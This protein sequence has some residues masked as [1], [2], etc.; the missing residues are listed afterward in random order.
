MLFVIK[1]EAESK[2]QM[3]KRI[4]IYFFIVILS[5]VISIPLFQENFD[6]Y[7][8]D[9]VQHICRLMGTYQSITEEQ[10]FPVIM[11]NFCNS[12]GYSWNLFYSPITAYVPLL[13][14]FLTHSFILDL[15]LFMV[16]VT[17]LSGIAMYE[18]VYKVTK[19]KY[20]SLLGA[21]IYILAPYRLTDMYIRMAVAELAS[22]I[23]LPII[24]GGL[25]GLFSDEEEEK[26]KNGI[27]LTIGAIG[28]I[29][30]HLI[31]A[32]YTA[33]IGFIYV[34]IHIK[35]LK[36]KNLLK[37][38]IIIALC[39]LCVTSFFWAPLLE[40]KLKTQ[41]EVFKEGRMER[42]ETLIE[43][44]LDA[45][46]LIYT[47]KGKMCFEIGLVTLIGLVLTM[48]VVNKIDT[49]Y[50]KM[51]IFS[52]II[53]TISIIMTL[54]WFPFEKLPSILKMLQFSYRMLEFEV[55]FLSFAVAVNYATL[56][57]NFN[58]KDVLVLTLLAFLLVVP[59]TKCLSYKENINE[60]EKWPA[61]RVTQR[62]GRVHAGCASFEYLPSKAFE[63]LEYIKIRE[64]KVYVLK[65]NAQ[66]LN[67]AKKRNK[68]GV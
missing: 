59:L 6:I 5:I 43:K 24:F 14:H 4:N 37:Q 21:A 61:V 36:D 18:F 1:K 31:M 54:K 52:I 22:F 10:S 40:H 48:L 55:F 38:L 62:T 16:F 7:R 63:H 35:K 30:T 11:S 19:N 8:D 42:T 25:Y 60:N 3:K 45:T 51:Y 46:S 20:T 15:K 27:I 2:N 53:G 33:I 56:I 64:D 9:G 12:F 66:V 49:R 32:M 17:I 13:L 28:L 57:K 47:Q 68:F 58:V 34:L 29:L 26:K 44:K 67:E 39:I 23:F 50:K 41:Y 65:G